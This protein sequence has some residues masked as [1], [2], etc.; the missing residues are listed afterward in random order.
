MLKIIQSKYCHVSLVK[1]AKNKH[2]SM[3]GKRQIRILSDNDPRILI[4]M[5]SLIIIVHYIIISLVFLNA[6]RSCN[7]LLFI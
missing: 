6:T 3:H 7:K 2:F 5:I 4:R 1:R